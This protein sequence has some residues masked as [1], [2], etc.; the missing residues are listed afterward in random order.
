LS[1]EDARA[2]RDAEHRAKE[3]ALQAERDNWTKTTKKP[4]PQGLRR[5]APK[6]WTEGEDAELRA[7]VEELGPSG[8]RRI[9][10]R[11]PGRSHV[12]CLQR[13]KK[14]LAPGLRKG[15]WTVEE[16]ERLRLAV[17][18]GFANWG[19][20]A[21]D[22]IGRTAKQCRE[23]WANYLAPSVVQG[24]WTPREDMKLLQLHHTSGRKWAAIARKLSGRSENGVKLR[25]KSLER[26][27]AVTAFVLGT[28]T[29]ET[30]RG[31]LAGGAGGS[32]VGEGTASATTGL[33]QLAAALPSPAASPQAA[34]EAA[35]DAAQG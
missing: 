1:A 26:H 34:P 20:V 7:A 8:W 32:A 17:A 19:A 2:Q 4:L 29:E 22:V 18:E 30:L 23:R 21:R 5:S 16:D 28:L 27:G 25:F 33:P 12:Q 14:V 10:E 11:V 35:D 13:W 6:K 9:A 31:M 15:Q 3:A 24:G